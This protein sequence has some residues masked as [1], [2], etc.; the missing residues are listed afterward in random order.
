MIMSKAIDE[1]RVPEGGIARPIFLAASEIVHATENHFGRAMPGISWFNPASTPEHHVPGMA[2]N[3]GVAVDFMVYG[4]REMGN[5]VADYA[6]NARNR[7]GLCWE[8]WQRQIRSNSWIGHERT[9]AWTSY[10]GP[11]PHTDHVHINFG[12]L[13]GVDGYGSIPVY[14][15]H[16]DNPPPP[17]HVI[18]HFH[19]KGVRDKVSPQDQNYVNDGSF[20]W[21]FSNNP[22]HGGQPVEKFAPYQQCTIVQHGHDSKGHQYWVTNYGKWL[23]AEFLHQDT[24]G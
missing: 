7:V 24:N 13:L 8:I 16:P 22:D 5:Y 20:L 14:H 2:G 10:T 17:P 18:G 19:V 1:L 11:N 15:Y 3:K 9:T 21:G 6:W 12:L 4:D 23:R